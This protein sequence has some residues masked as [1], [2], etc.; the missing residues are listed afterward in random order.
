MAV[1][2]L[3]PLALPPHLLYAQENRGQVYFYHALKE[4][5]EG[6]FVEAERLFRK[7]IEFESDNADF[8]FELG[9]LYIQAQALSQARPELEQAVMIKPN[10]LAAHYNLGL[11]YRDLGFTSEA[12]EEFR[13]VLQIDP[14]HAKAMLQIG[15]I[16]QN[17]GF[18]EDARQAFEEAYQMDVTN[19]EPQEALQDLGGLEQ[20][21]QE[22]SQNQ[23][24]RSLLQGQRFLSQPN[25]SSNP[26]SQ[27]GTNPSGSQ[28]TGRDALLQ[29]G[30][31]LI[32]QLLSKK[33]KTDNGS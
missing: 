22:R 21:A 25:S 3:L 14:N 28:P 17:E 18:Y 2:L 16:Y 30:T 31:L 23:M 11:V 26:L 1:C 6:R 27:F 8:H 13:R 29:A 15:Y 24:Q 20:Q 5:E 7:A 33:S 12:R 32:Q 10:H 19:P 4:R 9:N